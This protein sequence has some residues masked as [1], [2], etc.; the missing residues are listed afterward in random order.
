MEEED[1]IFIDEY[2]RIYPIA[3]IMGIS[4]NCIDQLFDKMDC[5]VW[6]RENLSHNN[7]QLHLSMVM[8]RLHYINSPFSLESYKGKSIETIEAVFG[9]YNV[10]FVIEL[11]QLS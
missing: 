3:S 2:P 6:I 9:K 10:R 8:K 7:K 1:W 11:L 4:K 5:S